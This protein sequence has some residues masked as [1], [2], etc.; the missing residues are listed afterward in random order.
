MNKDNC[1]RFVN[2]FDVTNWID[3]EKYERICYHFVTG[4]W[5]KVGRGGQD[6][7]ANNI[8]DHDESVGLGDFEDM[9]TSEK[10]E[11]HVNGEDVNVEQRRLK[12]LALRA[13]FDAQ[14][15]QLD[16]LI[17]FLCFVV[18][19]AIFLSISFL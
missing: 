7:D 17:F 4:D 14:Y 16:F 18:V 13:T 12:K 5:S 6:A 10:H 1:S 19:Y 3:E 8:D 9:E 11:S 15:P 2:H